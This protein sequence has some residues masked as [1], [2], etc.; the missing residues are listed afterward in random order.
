MNGKFSHT[1][2]INTP[3]PPGS[4]EENV[5]PSV[6][7]TTHVPQ[8][9]STAERR[10]NTE[11]WKTLRATRLSTVQAY[12]GHDESEDGE[13]L[14]SRAQE[15]VPQNFKFGAAEAK[16]ASEGVRKRSAGTVV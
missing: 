5:D 4:E 15:C 2:V 12:W 13:C 1:K 14:N 11:N 3:Y 7:D 10:A 6:N 9:H 16:T 8:P